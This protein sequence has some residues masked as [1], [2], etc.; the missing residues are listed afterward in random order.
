M[1]F[2]QECDKERWKYADSWVDGQDR[3]VL[4]VS[5]V[6]VLLLLLL[7]S[8]VVG[9]KK[10]RWALSDVGLFWGSGGIGGSLSIALSYRTSTAANSRP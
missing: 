6:L 1:V 9:H 8:G 7:A 10:F 2:I 4:L 5:L 3:M